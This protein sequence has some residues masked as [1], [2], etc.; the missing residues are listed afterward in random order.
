MRTDR[1]DTTPTVHGGRLGRRAMLRAALLF[2][3]SGPDHAHIALP[4]PR[5][6]ANLRDMKLPRKGILIRLGIYLPI[7][8]FLAWQAFFKNDEPQPAP[9]EAPKGNVRT[10][11]GPDGKEFKVI[12]VTP[13]EARAMGVEIPEHPTEPPAEAAEAPEEPKAAQ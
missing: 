5:H 6:A 12:E 9:E 11:S 10:F 13:E 7:I 2:Q 8:G 3:G 1:A 4:P